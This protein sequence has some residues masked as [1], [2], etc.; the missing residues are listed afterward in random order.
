MNLLQHL[1]L[2]KDDLI[3]TKMV[4]H[5]ANNKTINILGAVVVRL[6]TLS[7][8]TTETRQMIY[9]TTDTEK[10]FTSK[11]ACVAL[12]MIP[13]AFP[14]ATQTEIKA[15][16]ESSSLTQ[17]TN[18]GTCDCPIRCQPPP[19]PAK[20]PC[21]PT[22][23]NRQALE[24]HIK[25]YYRSSAF[26]TCPHM[27]GPPMN[28]MIS[29]DAKPIAYHKPIPVPIYWRDEVKAGLDQDVKLGVIKPVP[30][31]EP[32]SWCHRMIVCPKKTGKPRKTVD[33]QALNTY[34]RRETHHTQSPF[35]R[36]RSVPPYTK[37]TV[38]D[39]WNGYH[40]VPIKQEDSRRIG[41]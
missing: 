41:I 5:A 3:P 30:I 8:N 31:G 28:L 39:A 32:V 1:N 36:A 19:L 9:I 37:K 6:K 18:P 14:A 13:K 7:K 2:Q 24:Q 35:H 17:Q 33:L 15:T 40:S 26:N 16:T 29:D 22:P 23:G 12:G 4:M 21:A 11:E 25:D 27:S 20:L 10:M 34:A 38:L